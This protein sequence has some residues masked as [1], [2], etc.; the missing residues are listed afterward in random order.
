MAKGY[1]LLSLLLAAAAGLGVYEFSFRIEQQRTAAISDDLL[2]H[3][4]IRSLREYYQ[5][6]ADAEQW[7]N[8]PPADWATLQQD[9]F[10]SPLRPFMRVA[11]ED[12]ARLA[13]SGDWLLRMSLRDLKAGITPPPHLVEHPGLLL[14]LSS[15]N[16]QHALTIRL[17]LYEWLQQITAD[18]GYA[19]LPMLVMHQAQPLSETAPQQRGQMM[20]FHDFLVPEFSLYLD[21]SQIEKHFFQSWLPPA[22]AAVSA[23]V[24]WLLLLL[25]FSQYGGRKQISHELES[26]SAELEEANHILRTQL[27]L[28]AHSQKELLKSHYQL[29]SLNQDLENARNRL[30]LSERLAGL[31]ELSAGIAHEIN[32]PVAYISSNLKE[33]NNDVRALMDF[34]RA[35]DEASDLL[36]AKSDFYQQLLRVYQS[37]DI[38]HVISMAPERLQDCIRGTERV[39]WIINDMRKLSRIQPSMQWC[40]LNDDIRSVVHIARSRL[41]GNITLTMELIDLP[42]VFCNPSQISQVVM[43]ILVNAIQALEAS[44]GNIHIREVLENDVLN[45]SLCDDGPGMD[46]SVAARVFEPFFTTKLDSEGTGLGLALCYKLM[47][48]HQGSIELQ[49]APGKGACFTLIL[50]IGEKDNAE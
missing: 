14:L 10:S 47:Q 5:L 48:E 20:V 4:Y 28:N 18:M 38:A 40:Q 32:N 29:Q 30:L 36:D 34:V 43:N 49:T 37:L 41:P 13:V 1:V 12:P 33:L 7:L 8:N 11:E 45:L 42:D 16:Q 35:I 25:L 31:G 50:P 27:E 39:T 24:L 15:A 23:T 22:A 6:L 17:E 44:G 19:D 9:G 3:V 21:R 2:Q 26:R 46:A